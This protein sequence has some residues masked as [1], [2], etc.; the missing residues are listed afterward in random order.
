[1][2]VPPIRKLCSLWRGRFISQISSSRPTYSDKTSTSQ[3]RV[4]FNTLGAAFKATTERFRREKA[5]AETKKTETN[6]TE[7]QLEEIFH[8]K[9]KQLI[10]KLISIC[11]TIGISIYCYYLFIAPVEPN[12]YV[13]DRYG[14][15][16]DA[17]TGLYVPRKL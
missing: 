13:Y 10:S 9:R 11:V 14:R 12:N 3:T 17:Q 8:F 15:R 16:F 6:L 4:A 7:E 1:M 5:F 2:Q